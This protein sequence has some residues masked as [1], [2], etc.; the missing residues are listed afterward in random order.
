[1]CFTGGY[2]NMSDE[3]RDSPI[4]FRCI[5]LALTKGN[6]K[7]MIQGRESQ[8]FLR[9]W[10]ISNWVWLEMTPRPFLFA[11]SQGARNDMV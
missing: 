3:T 9:Y 7:Q 4:T 6:T 5:E 1:M 8:P 10:N 2:W 11:L